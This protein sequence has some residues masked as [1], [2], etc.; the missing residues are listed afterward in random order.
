MV[1]AT[2]GDGSNLVVEGTESWSVLLDNATASLG[3]QT[4]TVTASGADGDATKSVT[5]DVAAGGSHPTG[6]RTN[7]TYN[8]S[9]DGEELGALLYLPDDFDAATDGPVPLVLFMHGANAS[10]LIPGAMVAELEQRGWI[11]IGPDGRLWGIGQQDCQW[12]YSVA[13]VDSDDP[14]VG[15]GQQDML[16]AI[17]WVRENY[18][19]DP[20][21]IYLAGYSMGGRGAYTIGLKNPDMFAGLG[22]IVPPTDMTEIYERVTN[23]QTCLEG[24]TGGEPLASPAV[25]TMYKAIGSRFYLENAY[26]VPVHHSHGLNDRLS[27]NDASTPD[28]FLHGWHMTVDDSWDGCHGSSMYCFGHTPTLEELSARHPDGYDWAYM[29]TDGAHGIDGQY[30]RGGPQEGA[31][32]GTP[33]PENP[34]DL[35]GMAEFFSRRERQDAPETVVYKTY[36]ADDRQAYWLALD[37]ATPNLDRPAAVRATRDATSNAISAE[38]VRAGTLTFDLDRAG[39]SVFSTMTITVSELNEAVFDPALLPDAGEDL[40]PTVVLDADFSGISEVSVLRDGQVMD[41]ALISLE[42]D[43][44]AIGP[45]TIDQSTQLQITTS[46]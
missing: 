15:P 11:G 39:L 9:V 30:I 14:D 18:P 37:S 43:Q 29:F 10:G 46:N 17:T 42:S 3:S 13:Y 41:A 35:I 20:R 5:F 7:I 33:D 1:T 38:L 25:D 4:V 21:R 32:V 16:D 19:I 23:D 34:S 12:E 6:V 31:E 40:V 26:T 28:Q 22:A 44:L 45:L 36:R 27:F 24:M 2:L 8:S